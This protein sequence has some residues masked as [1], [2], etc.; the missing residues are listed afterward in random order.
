[1][2]EQN[3]F[4]D[5]EALGDDLAP[6]AEPKHLAEETDDE[7]VDETPA[8]PRALDALEGNPDDHV[9]EEVEGDA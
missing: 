5:G 8:E 2:N 3:Q 6:A 7:Q 1:M 4:S 9:G